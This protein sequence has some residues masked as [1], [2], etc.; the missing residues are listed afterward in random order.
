VVRF[1]RGLAVLLVWHVVVAG[2]PM[3][4]IYSEL[5]NDHDCVAHECLLTGDPGPALWL[6][7][8][9]AGVPAL[10]SLVVSAPTFAVLTRRFQWSPGTAVAVSA[11]AGLLGGVS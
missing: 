11:G 3:A 9:V 10:A 4:I 7:A 6:G 2:V 8:V 1:R 5:M